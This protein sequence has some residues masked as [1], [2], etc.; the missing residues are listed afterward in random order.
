MAHARELYERWGNLKFG[1]TGV[2]TFPPKPD[3]GKGG[4]KDKGNSK[5]KGKDNEKPKDPPPEHFE[6]LIRELPLDRLLIETDGP[7]MCPMP[8]RGQT[9]H[10]GHVHRVAERIAALK[11]VDL[12]RVM[13]ATRASTRDIYGV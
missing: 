5:G 8:F 2:I 9:A 12:A 3:K 10:P 1:F 11:G 7:Y 4:G 13:E 6:M